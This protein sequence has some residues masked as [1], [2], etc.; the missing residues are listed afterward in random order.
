MA[1]LPVW[2][3]RILYRL[4]T[5]HAFRAINGLYFRHSGTRC[6]L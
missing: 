3:E 4:E 6:D 5:Y 2:P 1:Y